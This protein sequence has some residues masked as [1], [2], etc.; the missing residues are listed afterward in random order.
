VVSEVVWAFSLWDLFPVSCSF[1][2][3]CF[4]YW[5]LVSISPWLCSQPMACAFNY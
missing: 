2:E 5:V 4:L 3:L 1:I